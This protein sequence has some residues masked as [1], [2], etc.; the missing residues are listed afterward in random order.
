MNAN[1]FHKWFQFIPGNSRSCLEHSTGWMVYFWI[2]LGRAVWRGSAALFRQELGPSAPLP[3]P[4]SGGFSSLQALTAV[5]S[6]LVGW[7]VALLNTL[8]KWLYSFAVSISLVESYRAK[9]LRYSLGWV[10]P[11]VSLAERPEPCLGVTRNEFSLVSTI[12][13]PCVLWVSVSSLVWG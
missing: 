2:V 12:S 13:S 6:E 9:G 4:P 8:F 7:R 5:P 3:H 11:L 1:T 10:Q